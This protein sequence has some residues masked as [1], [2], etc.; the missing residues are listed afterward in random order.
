MDMSMQIMMMGGG[1]GG[2]EPSFLALYGNAST[3]LCYSVATDA[4]GNIVFGGSG[5]ITTIGTADGYVTKLSKNGTLLWSKAVGAGAETTSIYVV[6][7][8][9]NGDVIC[10]GESTE[11]PYGSTDAVLLKLSGTD[12][13]ITWQREIGGAGADQINGLHIDSSDNIYASIQDNG[14]AR[15]MT[16][17]WN[18]SGT[19]QWQRTLANAGAT[20][21]YAIAGDASGNTV[22]ITR[23]NTVGD[24]VIVKRNASGT[25][26]WQRQLQNTV[27]SDGG[28][29]D[30][31]GNVYI[32]SQNS[33]LAE[34]TKIN[35][36]GTLVW[37]RKV[38][39]ALGATPSGV[40]LD[41]S[42]DPFVATR[43]NLGGSE[44]TAYI[45]KW[46]SSGALQFQ[47]EVSD[48]TGLLDSFFFANTI[49]SSGRIVAVGRTNA[50]GA[51]S[52]DAL[53]ARLP[54]DGTGTGTVGNLQYAA[55]T[56][57]EA[58][59]SVTLATPTFTDAAGALTEAAAGLSVADLS[60]TLEVL[61]L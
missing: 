60:I 27:S 12:G 17:K 46:N 54:E 34:L 59:G 58:A 42:G 45:A 18:S 7:I 43:A 19:L 23:D 8:D 26:Q 48:A 32:V 11:P 3:N 1:G 35:T 47:N 53:I 15:A 24:G 38:T 10:G 41:A 51:G 61:P 25:L 5:G 33:T 28:A 31:S 40:A 49:D 39:G 29:I 44:D 2:I 57:T 13:S 22:T 14:T 36:S 20:F 55:T 16:A 52:F 37:T 50:D 21:C 6:A 9:S 30:S 4:S 56:Y